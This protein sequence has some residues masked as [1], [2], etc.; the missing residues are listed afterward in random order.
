MWSAVDRRR[1]PFWSPSDVCTEE[2]V[3]SVQ[4]TNYKTCCWVSQVIIWNNT[5]YYFW[6]SGLQQVA[7]TGCQGLLK[8]RI[9]AC[10]LPVVILTCKR[11]VLSSFFVD[12]WPWIRPVLTILTQKWNDKVCSGSIQ[13]HLEWSS[14]VRPHQPQGY[15]VCILRQR[16]CDDRPPVLVARQEYLECI[17]HWISLQS[18]WSSQRKAPK[19][20]NTHW[21][22]LHN[23]NAP[24]NT[25]HVAIVALQCM[26]V[27][28]N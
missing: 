24:A 21:V 28:S 11:Q 20:V 9:S 22:L 13:P 19:T 5:S 23:D 16:S 2:N 6:C 17:L 14:F 8:S 1:A 3:N 18:A 10:K 26:S 4:E 12:M 27:P 25:F 7:H 15:G